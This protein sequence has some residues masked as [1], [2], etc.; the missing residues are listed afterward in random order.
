MTTATAIA[1]KLK[2]RLE[3]EVP[4]PSSTAKSLVQYWLAITVLFSIPVL[5]VTIIFVFIA[6]I[7]IGVTML[8]IIGP[9]LGVIAF[10][11]RKRGKK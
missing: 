8:S 11:Q 10:V 6:A 1:K 9:I 7:I 4:K 2:K 3:V 5:L